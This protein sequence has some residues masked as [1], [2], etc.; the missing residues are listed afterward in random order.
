VARSTARNRRPDA[1]ANTPR[2]L[3]VWFAFVD[4][5][6]AAALVFIGLK[7]GGAGLALAWPLAGAFLVIAFLHGWVG[8]R[9]RQSSPDD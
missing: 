3:V 4:L 7:V 5:L 1:A 6:L 9:S 2:P 8:L